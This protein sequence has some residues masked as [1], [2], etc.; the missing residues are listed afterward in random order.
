VSFKLTGK[1]G[2]LTVEMKPIKGTIAEILEFKLKT[3]D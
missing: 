1:L 2:K 3:R